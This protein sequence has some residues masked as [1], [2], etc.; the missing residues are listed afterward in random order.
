V[1]RSRSGVSERRR[2]GGA[3]LWFAEKPANDR[4]VVR[5]RRDSDIAVEL[6][7]CQWFE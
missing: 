4:D 6:D 1:K 7:Q 2:L 5:W 3:E